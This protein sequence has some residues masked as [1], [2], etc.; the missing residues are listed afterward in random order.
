[1]RTHASVVGRVDR[2]NGTTDVGGIGRHSLAKQARFP[3]RHTQRPGTGTFL[4][5]HLLSQRG[6]RE[7]ADVTRTGRYNLM[8][9]SAFGHAGMYCIYQHGF[10]T[11]KKRKEKKFH[12]YHTV[13][14]KC[15]VGAGRKCSCGSAKKKLWLKITTVP[16]QALESRD[17]ETKAS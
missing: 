8:W 6:I 16:L 13:W 2:V 9:L 14:R 11:K 5:P 15:L 4:F 17:S 12:K 3:M 10:L 7:A 1:M